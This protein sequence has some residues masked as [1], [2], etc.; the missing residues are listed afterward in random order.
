MTLGTAVL[1]FS[2]VA[3]SFGYVLCRCHAHLSLEALCK[4]FRV[5]KARAIGNLCYADVFAVYDSESLSYSY[6]FYKVRW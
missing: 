5:R 3:F 6:L 2:A 1:A 4:I